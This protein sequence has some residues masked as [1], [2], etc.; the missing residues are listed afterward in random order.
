MKKNTIQPRLMIG[1][2]ILSCFAGLWSAAVAAEALTPL[3]V[4]QVK[5]GGE[6]GRRID[7]TVTNNLL[8]L[9]V[10]KDFLRPFQ[11]KRRPDGYVGLGK[12][13]EAAV[14]FAAYTKSGET[15]ALK[16]RLVEETVKTQEPD[17]YIGIMAKDARMWRMWDIHEMGYI[18]KG[19]VTDHR[20]FAEKRSLDAAVRLADYIIR[21]W[22]SMPSDWSNQ[23]HY[24]TDPVVMGLDRAMVAL[25]RETGERRFLTFCVKERSLLTWDLGI[26]IGRRELM[27]GDASAYFS[28]CLAQLDWYRLEPQ[29]GLLRQSRRLIRFL[30]DGDGMCITGGVGQW[31]VFTDDQDAR[32][33]L[34]ETCATVYQLRVFDGLLQIEGKPVYGDLLERT[35][36]NTLFAAQSPDGR[37]LRYYAPLEGEREYFSSDTYCCPCNYRRA[38]SEL[39]A[40]VYYQSKTGVAV[41]LYTPSQA[42]VELG[43]NVPLRIRQETDYPSS[44]KVVIRLDPSKPLRFPL[45]L[46]IP[47]WCGKAAV[48]VNGKP[49]EGGAVPGEFLTVER[50]WAAG[51]RVTLDLPMAWRLVLGRK[52]QS[53][54]AA[55][56]RGPVVFCLDPAQDESLRNRDGADLGQI[57]LDPAS[58]A[59]APAGWDA[60]RPGGMACHVKAGRGGTGVAFC[61]GLSLRLTEFSDPAG[62]AVYF[63]LPDPRAA[64]P[65]GLL[66]GNGK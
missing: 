63:R 1:I 60:V 45:Q 38:I 65:D 31:E 13:I 18:I 51:D 21:R 43:G 57:V 55:V 52:R 44:G 5:V 53:G 6:I 37:K 62:R 8:M 26:V 28:K 36:Y 27:E 25:Y 58:L 23:T 64:V 50:E 17:G 66:T 40:M 19:L 16:K 12:T 46:R 34:G 22:P 9:D 4:R 41:N 48:N 24:C 33:G 56:M 59:D 47:H 42:D 14:R 49:W 10:D 11:E 30:K 61:S 2:A 32:G 54:R 39:P 35:I 15:L 7:M 20:Y 29:P 3:D